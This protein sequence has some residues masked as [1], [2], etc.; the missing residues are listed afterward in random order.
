LS[1]LAPEAATET[2]VRLAST[3]LLDAYC[4]QRSSGRVTLDTLLSSDDPLGWN[5]QIEP[6]IEDVRIAR[7]L[8]FMDG[9][10][11]SGVTAMRMLS[12]ILD[13][14]VDGLLST[15]D[16]DLL[17]QLRLLHD[18]HG[19]DTA[20]LPPD[21]SSE[22]AKEI[23]AD[24]LHRDQAEAARHPGWVRAFSNA[25]GI[26]CAIPEAAWRPDQGDPFDHV[27]FLRHGPAAT[28]GPLVSV[29]TSCYRPDRGLVSAIQSL[30]QQTWTNLEMLVVDDGSGQAFDDILREVAE[31]DPRVRV[32]R[33]EVNR[34]TYARRNQALDLARGC[35]I[36][37][38]DADDLSVP[39]RVRIH[40]EMM[41]EHRAL[42]G[43]L[44]T[45]A[46][47][48][49]SLRVTRPG[50]RSVSANAQSL[51]LRASTALPG[52][53]YFHEVRRG[54]DGEY[55]RRLRAR[56]G[57]QAISTIG[58]HPLMLYR[59]R[60]GSL[61]YGDFSPGRRARRRW[62]YQEITDRQ[63]R[64]VTQASGYFMTR[65]RARSTSVGMVSS[66][67]SPSP[68]TTPQTFDVAFLGD[69][70]AH[71]T[72]FEALRIEVEQ[73]LTRGLRVAVGQCDRPEQLSVHDSPP[74]DWV[75]D[76]LLDGD[77]HLLL[78][79]SVALVTHLIVESAEAVT[80]GLLPRAGWNAQTAE[81]RTSV[82]TCP[83]RERVV[84]EATAVLEALGVLAR[85]SDVTG[86]SNQ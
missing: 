52:L 79:D 67:A 11:P 24:L 48:E 76:A 35:Y 10:G 70:R 81:M 50:Y 9:F 33:N 40:V 1:H 45:C 69:F 13:A 73:A 2:A 39:D 7:A 58:T 20:Q 14:R 56:F 26:D 77:V 59:R 22:V 36:T 41:E 6:S 74:A 61:S 86:G 71:N 23:T 82:P 49:P 5:Q 62:A 31:L 64:R 21:L 72:E 66:T 25:V 37:F 18:Q 16:F 54:A 42:V 47:V 29:I 78:E 8:A 15:R 34:G 28:E 27:D 43:T 4:R 65:T 19:L 75:L 53:G 68:W 57:N 80:L 55:I 17:H 3:R 32:V 46:K 85:S 83:E 63:H 51:M 12:Q 84:R 38:Q 44:S 30:C 60:P